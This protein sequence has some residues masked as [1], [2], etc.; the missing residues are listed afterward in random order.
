VLASTRAGDGVKLVVIDL[1]TSANIDLAGVRML[2]ELHE[3]LRRNGVSLSLAEVHGAV[4]DLSEAEGLQT[5]I[6]GIDQRLGVAALI[7]RGESA[8]PEGDRGA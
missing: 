1:S 5:K 6:P 3:E 2:S 7:R 8:S 4:R